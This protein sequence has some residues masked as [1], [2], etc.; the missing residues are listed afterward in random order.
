MSAP[1]REVLKTAAVG[2]VVFGVALF[3]SAYISRYVSDM[4]DAR[5][6]SRNDEAANANRKR[7]LQLLV[8]RGRSVVEAEKL[9]SLRPTKHELQILSEVVFPDELHTTFAD[10]GGHHKLKRD[11]Y[12]SLIL[13]LQNPALFR[14]LHHASSLLSLPGGVLFY[15]PP[16]T[17][18]FAAG[19]HVALFFFFL[20][21]A[22]RL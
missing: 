1:V 6:T 20:F 14:E 18:Q 7:L 12:E 13:P 9:A 10:I 16:G 4:M 11:I 21:F 5:D 15:G 3:A 19:M 8:S 22:L 2:V 17:G